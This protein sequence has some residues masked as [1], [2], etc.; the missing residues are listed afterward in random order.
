MRKQ[1]ETVAPDSGG[2]EKETETGTAAAPAGATAAP[3]AA[4]I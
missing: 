4:D 3:T 2:K 1:E